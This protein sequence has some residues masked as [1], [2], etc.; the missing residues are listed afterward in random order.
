MV[1]M[2]MLP[3]GI[4][5]EKPHSLMAELMGEEFDYVP[6][7]RGDIRKGTIVR[8]DKDVIIGHWGKTRRYCAES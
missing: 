7:R 5:E 3:E 6:P 2:E 1:D 8:I 4:G